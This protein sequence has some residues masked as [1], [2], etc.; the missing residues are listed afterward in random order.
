MRSLRTTAAAV[1]LAAVGAAAWTAPARA[2]EPTI[3]VKLI[4]PG[5]EPREALRYAP[6]VELT[7]T[8]S[9]P[10]PAELDTTS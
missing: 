8:P 3:R 1:V 4:S 7:S 6:R 5:A 9:C 2:E 10:P